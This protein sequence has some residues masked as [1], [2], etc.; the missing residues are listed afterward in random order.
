M[1]NINLAEVKRL[2]SMAQSK[3]RW[4]PRYSKAVQD[5]ICDLSSKL[6]IK[7]ICKQLNISRYFVDKSLRN[8]RGKKPKSPMSTVANNSDPLHQLQF[9]EIPNSNTTTADKNN[10]DLKRFMKVTTPSGMIIEVWG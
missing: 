4:N 8:C 5:G 10:S 7:E 1:S 9:L 6:S 3:N 2:A